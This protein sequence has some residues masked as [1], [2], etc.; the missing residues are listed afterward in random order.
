MESLNKDVYLDALLPYL[1]ARD[2]GTVACASTRMRVVADTN[3]V[4]RR[5]YMAMRKKTFSITPTSVHH[6]PKR[7]YWCTSPVPMERRSQWMDAGCPCTNLAHYRH[8]TLMENQRKAANYHYFKRAYAKTVLS[9]IGKY[10]CYSEHRARALV[11]R[12]ADYFRRIRRMQE[13]IDEIK[14]RKRAP[15]KFETILSLP[16][17]TPPHMKEGSKRKRARK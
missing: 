3:E 12:Q 8:D 7:W 9:R 14:K 15:R 1:T 16:P 5:L 2:L 11:S 6:I 13:E 4:W 10:T 17:S